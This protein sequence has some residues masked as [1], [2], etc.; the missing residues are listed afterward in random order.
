[1]HG[2]YTS[3]FYA[4]LVSARLH[5]SAPCENQ[6]GH[7]QSGVM[8]KFTLVGVVVAALLPGAALAADLGNVE[9]PPSVRA[10]APHDWSGAYVGLQAGWGWAGVKPNQGD[11]IGFFGGPAA[12]TGAQPADGFVGGGTVSYN[13]QTGRWVVGLEGD[14]SGSTVN[15][16]VNTTIVG[17]GTAV[18]V[19]GHMDW[20]AT[21]RVRGGY[22]FGPWLVY[23]TG[24]L[25]A[26]GVHGNYVGTAA[27]VGTFTAKASNTH[28]GWT[29]GAGVEYALSQH[30]SV[31]LEGLYAQLDERRY[32]AVRFS[33]EFAVVRA[34]V[35]YRF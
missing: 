8:M 16:A 9:V 33:S 28:L 25:A 6:A 5:S 11:V 2:G 27:G 1:M 30:W 13:Y 14:F 20:F 19:T 4:Q 35:N 18:R 17:V 31:K 21:A 22:T 34:G 10:L 3:L 32:N 26:A 29:L 24:G 15:G 12:A 7:T 23:A